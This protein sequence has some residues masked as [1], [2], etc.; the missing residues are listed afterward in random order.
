MK[1]EIFFL[2]F[3]P[4]EILS[5]GSFERPKP[6]P[7]PSSKPSKTPQKCPISLPTSP[8]SPNAPWPKPP[9]TI[10]IKS[11]ALNYGNWILILGTNCWICPHFHRIIAED[12]SL[13]KWPI[14]MESGRAAMQGFLRGVFGGVGRCCLIAFLVSLLGFGLWVL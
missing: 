6:Q 7:P 1:R 9:K 8:N 2:L 3:C 10:H 5:C 4:F 11:I 14:F 12:Y 13:F